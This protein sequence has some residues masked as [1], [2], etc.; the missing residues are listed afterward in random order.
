MKLIAEHRY[1]HTLLV[2][3]HRKTT[4]A[5]CEHGIVLDHGKVVEQGLL[6]RLSYFRRMAGDEDEALRA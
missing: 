6:S 3:S 5:A 1:F 4:L 2:I